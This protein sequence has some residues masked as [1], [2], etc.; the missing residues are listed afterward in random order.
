MHQPHSLLRNTRLTPPQKH[1]QDFSIFQTKPAK[2]NLKA[3]IK[4]K[5]TLA[6]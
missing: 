5:D 6:S 3:E 4:A 2:K 1:E